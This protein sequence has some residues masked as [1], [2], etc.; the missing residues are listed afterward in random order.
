MTHAPPPPPAEVKIRTMRS[1]IASMMRS[2]GGSPSFQSV[3]VSGLSM[4]RGYRP[5]AAVRTPMPASSSFSVPTA[6]VV[7]VT[8][9]HNP[10]PEAETA[11]APAGKEIA[12]DA[13]AGSNLVPI[14]IVVFVAIFAI[15][16]VGYFAYTM[17]LK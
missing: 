7:P 4:E 10:A 17:F 9:I 3:S 13:G 15:A 11:P 1:D 6:P 14:L 16:I 12:P 8:T 2:G 5:E